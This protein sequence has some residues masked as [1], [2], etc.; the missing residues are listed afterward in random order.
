MGWISQV[1]TYFSGMEMM[2]S[3][4]VIVA[5]AGATSRSR[6]SEL[7]AGYTN[8]QVVAVCSNT[9]EMISATI[10]LKPDVLLLDLDMPDRDP[11]AALKS[12]PAED[13]PSIILTAASETWAVRAFEVRALD[14]L[15]KPYDSTRLHQAIERVRTERLSAHDR[16]ITYQLLSLLA[17]AQN[18][19]IPERRIAIKVGGR[20]LLLEQDQVDWIEADGNY[21][22]V[23]AGSESYSLR[24][25]I[26]HFHRRLDPKLFVRIHR[27]IIVNVRRIRELQPCNSGEYMVVLKDGKELSCSR[28]Y[29]SG[30]RSIIAAQ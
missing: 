17:G 13:M 30:L 7:L 12:L 22:R 27:S 24:E 14:F 21:V 19:A 20:V 25:G 1:D 8:L 26:G 6:L 3:M 5:D 16:S 9:A 23:R 28:G 29:R 10:D 15:L 11:I 2:S 4:R 18:G